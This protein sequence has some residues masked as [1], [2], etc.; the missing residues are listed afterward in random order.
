VLATQR[1]SRR[2]EHRLVRASRLGFGFPTPPPVVSGQP[3]GVYQQTYLVIG[4]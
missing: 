1:R 2:R 3:S 4:V